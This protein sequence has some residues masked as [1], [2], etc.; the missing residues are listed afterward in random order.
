M[1]MIVWF[2]QYLFTFVGFVAT[3][4]PLYANLKG[5]DM[6]NVAWQY[7]AIIG[8]TLLW[9]SLASIIFRLYIENRRFHSQ[10]YRLQMEKLDREVKQ[11]RLDQYTRDTGK[12]L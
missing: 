4:V 12:L 5:M 11:L 10:E 2:I 1:K 3:Y 7:W 9:L 6:W 8:V